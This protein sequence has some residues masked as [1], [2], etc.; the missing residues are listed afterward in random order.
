MAEERV[1]KEPETRRRVTIMMVGICHAF[2]WQIHGPS[3]RFL[4]VGIEN[5][6]SIR[7]WHSYTE[8]DS[9]VME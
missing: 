2:M 9:E 7:R 5:I 4:E 3:T 1:R 6:L 8:R